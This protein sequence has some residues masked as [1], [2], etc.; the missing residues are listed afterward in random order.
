MKLCKDCAHYRPFVEGFWIFR[1]EHSQYAKCAES[2]EP[3]AG[4]PEEFCEFK[5]RGSGRCG[6]TAKLFVATPTRGAE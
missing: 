1:V 4:K 2:L 6:P 5:R 3:I